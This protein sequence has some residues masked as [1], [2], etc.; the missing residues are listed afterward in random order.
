MEESIYPKAGLYNLRVQNSNQTMF[1]TPPRF[2]VL[3]KLSEPQFANKGPSSQ[4]Y[5]FSSGHIWM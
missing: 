4:G 5:G 1:L 2:Q 3:S